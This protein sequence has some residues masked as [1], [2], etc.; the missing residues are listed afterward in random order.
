MGLAPTNPD[1]S[2]QVAV[3]DLSRAME[4]GIYLVD[5]DIFTANTG[6]FSKK[7]GLVQINRFNL[8]L[9]LLVPK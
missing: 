5:N 1:E 6:S 4:M 7:L 8:K 2:L 9:S 3:Q